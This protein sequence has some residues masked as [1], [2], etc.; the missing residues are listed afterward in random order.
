[1]GPV[2]PWCGVTVAAPSHGFEI[3]GTDPAKRALLAAKAARSNRG[4][5][6]AFCA[7]NWY[8]RRNVEGLATSNASQQSRSSP[9]RSFGNIAR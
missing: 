3:A 5:Y 9:S 4:A 1:M 2:E 6:P 8:M 7:Q